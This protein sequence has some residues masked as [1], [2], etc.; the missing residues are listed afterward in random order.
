MDEF[1]FR[2]NGIKFPN[3]GI[4][5]DPFTPVHILVNVQWSSA[6]TFEKRE[7]NPLQIAIGLWFV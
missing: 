6:D 3:N 4:Y 2:I 1:P 5:G 7:R